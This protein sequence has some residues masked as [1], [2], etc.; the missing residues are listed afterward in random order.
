LHLKE[1]KNP[2]KNHSKIELRIEIETGFKWGQS[3]KSELQV[4]CKL[5]HP[6]EIL[7]TSTNAWGRRRAKNYSQWN[8]VIREMN[9]HPSTWITKMSVGWHKSKYSMKGFRC[10]RGFTV[11]KAEG[12]CD[13]VD[14]GPLRF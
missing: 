2:G 11:V 10:L 5:Q 12:V 3:Y 7:N 13:S 14:D 9:V 6:V 4:S 8:T 1:S